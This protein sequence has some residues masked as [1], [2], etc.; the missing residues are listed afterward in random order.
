MTAIREASTMFA[1]MFSLVVFFILFESRLDRK[2]TTILTLCLM[3][4]LILVNFILLVILGPVVMSTLLLLTCSLPS[5]CFFLF[6]SKYRDGRFFFTFCFADTLILEIIYITAILDFYLKGGYWIML[7]SRL[8]L[9]PVLAFVVFKWV[10]PVYRRLQQ[11]VKAGWGISASIALLFYIIL[12]VEISVPTHITLR[13]EQLPGFL[14]QL[15]LMPVIYIHFFRTLRQQQMLHETDMQEKILQLQVDNMSHR[16]AEFQ[17][18]EQKFRIER[19]D[20][21]HNL[22]TIDAL[23]E[24]GDRENI[25]ELIRAYT[26]SSQQPLPERYCDKTALDAVLSSYLRKAREQD[27]RLSLRLAF[28]EE[29]PVNETELATVFANALENAIHA[30]GDVPVEKR[31]LEISVM[32]DPCFMFQIRNS[33]AHPVS[34]DADGIPVS[35]RQNHGFGTRS[36]AAFCNKHHADFEFKADPNFFCLRICFPRS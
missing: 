30:C 13:P 36:I 28:P 22:Q 6:L 4:P 24:S 17:E 21:R 3:L 7:V 20:Y 12:S 1:S 19:H 26:G 14:L 35:P 29:L 10:R 25:R 32:T 16:M 5:L 34:F 11:D 31:L 18:F 23:L 8:I 33:Y 27:I 2:K 15:I 9:C